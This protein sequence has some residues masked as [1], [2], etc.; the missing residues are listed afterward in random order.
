MDYLVLFKAFSFLL[1]LTPFGALFLGV[2]VFTAQE[3]LPFIIAGYVLRNVRPSLSSWYAPALFCFSLPFLFTFLAP[4]YIPI[5]STFVIGLCS[6]LLLAGK[7]GQQFFLGLGIGATAHLILLIASLIGYPLISEE[8]FWAGQRRFG[9]LFTD[10]NAA[11]LV[12]FLLLGIKEVKYFSLLGLFTGSRSYLIGLILSLKL[13]FSI[14]F[15]ILL[16]ILL[17][18]VPSELLP[19][20]FSRL[21]SGG[22]NDRVLFWWAAVQDFLSSPLT[23][24]GPDGFRQSIRLNHHELFGNW[25]D[26]PNNYYLL[27]LSEWG[28]AGF[29]IACLTALR[30]VKSGAEISRICYVF[31][32]LLFL[33]SHLLS[34]EVSV[35]LAS[36]LRPGERSLSK[37]Y[38]GVALGVIFSILLWFSD[39][40]VYPW[41]RDSDGPFRWTSERAVFGVKCS[42]DVALIKIERKAIVRLKSVVYTGE[43]LRIP[44]GSRSEVVVTL[45]SSDPFMPPNDKRVLGAKLRYESP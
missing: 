24:V 22:L 38:T 21:L 18:I 34:L 5:D 1:G 35:V 40:G 9:G 43:E 28:I 6:F 26:N 33:G 29:F 8:S 45:T 32:A 36:I 15:F 39:R 23:G 4:P 19:S 13:R 31:F 30:F 25:I 42:D 11:G 16:A 2:G 41:E 44:C 37:D 20:S 3:F 17:L 14:I 7:L 27:I 12:F 10:P